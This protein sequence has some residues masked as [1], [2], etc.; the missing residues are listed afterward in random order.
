MTMKTIRY[1]SVLLILAATYTAG[2]YTGS[3]I[4]GFLI[5]FGLLF[6]FGFIIQ[7]SWK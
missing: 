6:I 4:S 5:V 2:K 7:K 1:I 3:L